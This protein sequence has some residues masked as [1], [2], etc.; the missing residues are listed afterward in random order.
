MTMV[1][2]DEEELTQRTELIRKWRPTS[3]DFLVDD[4]ENMYTY[5]WACSP[6]P[7]LGYPA[8]EPPICPSTVGTTTAP[9]CNSSA[10]TSATGRSREEARGAHYRWLFRMRSD[11]VALAPLPLTALAATDREQ[12][13]YLPLGGFS[14]NDADMCASDHLFLCPRALCRSYFEL[15]ELWTSPLCTRNASEATATIFATNTPRGLVMATRPRAAFCCRM[16]TTRT[17]P[18]S[19]SLITSAH[20]ISRTRS[21]TATPPSTRHPAVAS[22]ASW[23][24]PTASREVMRMQECSSASTHSSADGARV[25][26]KLTAA[27]RK[28]LR[29]A[30]PHLIVRTQ[31]YA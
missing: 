18:P 4:A 15:T 13:A 25:I 20:A 14:P 30:T 16:P 21:E 24:G 11:L 3:L 9:Y 22:C 23:H 31:P 27:T 6:G 8:Q 29:S 26:S 12:F 17:P 2:T 7:S 5:P 28:L 1:M 10:S 19:R